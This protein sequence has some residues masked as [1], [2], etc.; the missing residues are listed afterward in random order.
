MNGWRIS[1]G[2]KVCACRDGDD[3]QVHLFRNFT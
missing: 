3:S 1:T 2:C